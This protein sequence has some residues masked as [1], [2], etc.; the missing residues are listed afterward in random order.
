MAGSIINWCLEHSLNY[1]Q[2]FSITNLYNEKNEGI[3]Y[4]EILNKLKEIDKLFV[5]RDYQVEL[6]IKVNI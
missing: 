5:I 3:P 4:Q 1:S 2:K 6:K